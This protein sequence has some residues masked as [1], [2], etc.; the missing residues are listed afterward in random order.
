MKSFVKVLGALALSAMGGAAL[1]QQPTVNPAPMPAAECCNHWSAPCDDCKSGGFYLDA[2]VMILRPR[3]DNNLAFNQSFASFGGDTQVTN[4]QSIQFDPDFDLVPRI[5]LGFRMADGLGA[6]VR[7]WQGSWSDNQTGAT[8]TFSL[9]GTTSQSISSANPLNLG[10]STNQATFGTFEGPFAAA[11]SVVAGSNLKIVAWDFEATKET[12]IAC[13]DLLFSGGIRYMHFSQNYSF[14][15][16]AP[17]ADI[18]QE[19]LLISGHNLNGA[20]PTFAI[21]GRYNIGGG[22][23]AYGNARFAVLFCDAKQNAYQFYEV[24]GFNGN[25]PRIDTATQSRDTVIPLTELEVGGEYATSMGNSELFLRLGIVGN[26]YFS[27]GNTT[28]SGN[29]AN[30]SN[31][32]LGLIGL[33]IYGG[34]RF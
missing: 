4:S 7:W 26:V 28:R 27:A 1:A 17:D 21:D 3:W 16:S 9:F 34:V 8:P 6:R 19:M 14:A 24:A 25:I 23:S 22:L 20:G 15:V 33:A 18:N 32:N 30:E 31:S 11:T 5:T 2:G 10:L 13:F 29:T 12:R